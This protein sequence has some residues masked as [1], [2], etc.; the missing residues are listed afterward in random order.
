[1]TSNET[2]ATT[3]VHGNRRN[4]YLITL[5]VSIAFMALGVSSAW[6]TPVL[7][8]FKNNETNVVINEDQVG[9]MLSLYPVG[10]AVGS[11][12]TR[13]I[14]D[15]FGRR[16][17]ILCSA[18]PIVIGSVIV[19][20]TLQ[21]WLLYITALTWNCG[22]G[23]MS[24]VIGY[25]VSEIADKDVRA[26]LQVITSFT[27]K[28]GNLITMILGPFLSYEDLNYIMVALPIIYF[29]V[30]WWIPETPYFFLKA[31]NV[32]GAKKSLRI[33]RR[34]KDEKVLDDELRSLQADVQNEMIHSSSIKELL[35]GPQYRKAIIIALG[36]K[37]A[38]IMTG[39][40]LI[41]QYLGWIVGE[42]K[43]DMK[44][45]LVLII[46]GC[47]TFVVAMMSSVLVD[48]VGRRSLLIYSF[49]GTGV[50]LGLIGLYFFLQDVMNTGSAILT[51]FG[52]VPLVCIILS[53]IISTL[54]FNSLIHIV[55]AE[56][57]PL[58]VKA[59]AMTSL[60][61]FG[62]LM[63]FI[64][65]QGYPKVKA[66]CGLTTIFFIFAAF[67]I[68]GGVFSYYFVIETKGKK[69][70]DIQI[71]L[72]GNMYNAVEMVENVETVVI[73]EDNKNGTEQKELKSSNT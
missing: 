18:I 10:F 28:F 13:Y 55:P 68:G 64:V 14:A 56:I 7:P 29:V 70:R 41:R 37:M 22:T 30:C 47:V 40:V 20:F 16:A 69:L 11:L 19:A 2:V 62:A 4:L 1:M 9:T 23:M 8:K 59:V 63:A 67:S 32:E 45:S 44:M 3:V 54:G 33:L 35:S 65:G 21:G 27:F 73:D 43:L 5:S 71:E 50:A 6:P 31:G 72:Q 58:N 53:N 49:Y 17:T 24:T 60:N 52:F 48:R 12:A 61:I 25:Y 34:Y 51:T 42:T 38:Q 26:S 36:L 39:G 46:Y 57:F 66:A 15:I